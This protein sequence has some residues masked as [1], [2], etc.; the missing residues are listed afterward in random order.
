MAGGDAVRAAPFEAMRRA[1]HRQAAHC[2]H[3]RIA[4]AEFTRMGTAQQ[5]VTKIV[6][7]GDLAVYAMMR[8]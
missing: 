6:T 1:D 8:L 3:G 5:D 7:D 2:F 4:G